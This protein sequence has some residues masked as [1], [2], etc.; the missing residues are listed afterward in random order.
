[1][2]VEAVYRKNPITIDE[3]AS[4]KDAVRLFLD[5]GSNGVLVV[6]KN[7][8]LVGILSLQDIMASIVPSDFREHLNLAHAMYKGGYFQEVCQE[9]ANKKVSEVMRKEFTV[10]E[11]DTN[12]MEIAVDFLQNDLY[13]IP[14]IENKKLIGVISRSELKQALAHALGLHKESK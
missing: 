11:K 2:L 6:N 9:V 1:M 10:A 3:N 13:I 12:L 8:H 5:K 7:H 14:V 4:I